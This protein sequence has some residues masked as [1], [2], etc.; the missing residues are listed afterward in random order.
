MEASSTASGPD[1]RGLAREDVIFPNVL[2]P[3]FNTTFPLTETSW[4]IFASKL[5]PGTVCE[6]MRL[7]VLTVTVVPAGIV[8]AFKDEAAKQAQHMAIN[9]VD[10]FCIIFVLRS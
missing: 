6:L 7:T 1:L 8:A 3:A 9:A 2:V 5:L 10:L 4:A